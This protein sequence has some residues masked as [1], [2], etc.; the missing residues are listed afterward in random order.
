MIYFQSECCRNIN[1]DFKKL[2]RPFFDF[3][4]VMTLT[5]V[6]FVVMV[7]CNKKKEPTSIIIEIP[8]IQVDFNNFIE[9]RRPYIE[10]VLI[11]HAIKPSASFGTNTDTDQ[12]VNWL[13]YDVSS[14]KNKIT[15][16]IR[17]TAFLQIWGTKKI[18]NVDVPEIIAPIF[19]R[20]DD[21]WVL[22]LENGY[23]S[24]LTSGDEDKK[25]SLPPEFHS[26]FKR[27]FP[28]HADFFGNHSS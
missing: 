26:D 22:V 24:E 18:Y 19:L 3:K 8:E 13:R 25:S 15:G 21:K 2:H 6:L 10:E 16:Q 9:A 11:K 14:S 7:G 23:L 17:S 5:I 12:W 27:I 1:Q 4:T 28:Y 20:E